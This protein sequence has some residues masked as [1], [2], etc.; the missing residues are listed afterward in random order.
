MLYTDGFLLY[1]HVQNKARLKGAI[2][3]T[4][5]FHPHSL[6][7]WRCKTLKLWNYLFVYISETEEKKSISLSEKLLDLKQS[8]VTYQ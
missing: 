4:D 7:L 8:K 3:S 1:D 2:H 6:T 5:V